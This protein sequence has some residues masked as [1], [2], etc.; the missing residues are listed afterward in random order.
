MPNQISE[1]KK[2]SKFE[3]KYLQPENQRQ[4]ELLDFAKTHYELNG[5]IQ[6]EV[7]KSLQNAYDETDI[8]K[9]DNPF[10][11]ENVLL[12]KV[13]KLSEQELLDNISDLQAKLYSNKTGK[14]NSADFEFYKNQYKSLIAKNSNKK[15]DKEEQVE[16]LSRNLKGDLKKS[17]IDRFTSYQISQ[18]DEIRKPFLEEL[19]KKIEKFMQL[20]KLLSPFIK[21]VGRL[22]DLSNGQFNT[23]GFEILEKFS[24][25]LEKDDSLR[26]LAELLGRQSR[27]QSAFEKELRDKTIIKTEWHPKPAYR[28]EISDLRYSNDIAA[29]V[30]SELSMMKNPAANKLFQL[31]FA[32]KQLLSFQY[33]NMNASSKEETC[34]E[35]IEVE[36]KESKGPIIICVDTSGSMNG[37]PENITKTV[38][39]ALSKIAIKEERKCFLISFSTEIETLDLSD[40]KNGDSLLK[41]VGFLRLS[42]N[43]GTDA[44][45]ALNHAVTM[46][47]KDGWKNADVLMISD[48]VMGTLPA[49]LVKSIEV[50][51]EKNTEFYSLVIGSS[52]N[53]GT[54]KCFNHNWFYNTHDSHAT[55]HLVEQLHTLTERKMQKT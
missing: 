19:Y 18:I 35:E 44:A 10:Y 40:F 52:G 3:E 37:T 27:A 16:I 50:E 2:I 54:I 36:K 47:R 24:D 5:Q 4:K 25:L 45:P 15:T 29:V 20:E 13:E 55:R 42:F 31:K 38:T 51:K 26:E 7:I 53:Q 43:G 30:P 6:E 28:G 21:N 46:L 32:Q 9:A 1:L 34:H 49:D 14:D 39:F 23:S 17:L 11:A 33:Q 8:T 12:N 41:L 22:W 48:F